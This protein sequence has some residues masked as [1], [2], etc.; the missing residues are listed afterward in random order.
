M[1]G[2]KN[3]LQGIVISIVC[4][5]VFLFVFSL[6]LTYTN[7]SETFIAPVIIVVTAISIFIGSSIGNF[8]MRRNGLINGAIIGGI[9]LLS[10]YMLSGII[11]HNFNLNMQSIIIIIVGIICG[12]FGG[13]IGVNKG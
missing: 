9:Y 2:L 3:I 4:T 8:N 1:E 10:I 13:V 12:M 11:N 5:F 7:V 6:I